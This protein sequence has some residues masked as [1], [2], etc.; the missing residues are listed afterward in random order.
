MLRALNC[1]PRGW[2]TRATKQDKQQK[3]SQGPRGDPA[4][5]GAICNGFIGRMRRRLMTHKQPGLQVQGTLLKVQVT[6]AG[7]GERFGG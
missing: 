6:Q 4:E 1:D 7:R 5:S 2:V 3:P